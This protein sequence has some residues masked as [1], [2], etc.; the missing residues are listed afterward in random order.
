MLIVNIIFALQGRFYKMYIIKDYVRKSLVFCVHHFHSTLSLTEYLRQKWRVVS[1]FAWN[2]ILR[3]YDGWVK[4]ARYSNVEMGVVQKEEKRD[5]ILNILV[6]FDV[7]PWPLYNSISQGLAMSWSTVGQHMYFM[8]MHAK[9]ILC[10]FKGACS[11]IFG[12]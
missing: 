4:M 3:N 8:M 12:N 5:F 6:M 1:V 10:K 11:E 7:L 2:D 9:I